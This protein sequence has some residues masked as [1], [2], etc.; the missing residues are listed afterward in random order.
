MAFPKHVPKVSCPPIFEDLRV[1]VSVSCHLSV[2]V[3][4]RADLELHG[5]TKICS[6]QLSKFNFPW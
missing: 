1:E 5:L 3:L 4:N 2:S 6:Y